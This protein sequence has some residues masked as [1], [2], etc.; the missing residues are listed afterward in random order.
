MLRIVLKFL[1]ECIF[2]LKLMWSLGIALAFAVETVVD[3]ML[4]VVLCCGWSGFSVVVAVQAWESVGLD[5][6]DWQK[7]LEDNPGNGFLAWGGSQRSHVGPVGRHGLVSS[8]SDNLSDESTNV[9]GHLDSLLVGCSSIF[10][11]ISN[12]QLTES[13]LQLSHVKFVVTFHL[14]FFNIFQVHAVVQR[15]LGVSAGP[16]HFPDFV[17]NSWQW[18]LVLGLCGINIE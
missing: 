5:L 16:V 9:K 18:L 1:F 12:F 2:R 8:V 11:I 14:L 17:I 4:N 6:S 3:Q 7:S 15:S 13:K 10:C